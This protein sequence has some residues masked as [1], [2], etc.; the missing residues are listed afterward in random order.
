VHPVFL[1]PPPGHL[2]A[3][4]RSIHLIYGE[5]RRFGVTVHFAELTAPLFQQG[6]SEVLPGIH[7]RS[8]A[9]RDKNAM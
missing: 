1:R 2:P 4:P 6:F 9:L 3:S 5:G 7:A 8:R